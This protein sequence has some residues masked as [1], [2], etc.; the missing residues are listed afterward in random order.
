[1]DS[2]KCIEQNVNSQ[3][4]QLYLH[5]SVCLKGIRSWLNLPT[6]V[7]GH[8]M[9]MGDMIV[10]C[11]GPYSTSCVLSSVGRDRDLGAS[12][13]QWVE[14]GPVYHT[15]LVFFLCHGFNNFWSSNILNWSFL[16]FWKSISCNQKAYYMAKKQTTCSCSMTLH[17][18]P[19][20]IAY[21]T[22]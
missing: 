4:S 20:A 19:N 12:G 21:A 9:C 1:M 15:H 11:V 22:E 3:V 5:V 7:Y 16:W 14:Y 18:I 2:L 17:H 13:L 10:W 8:V 6:G